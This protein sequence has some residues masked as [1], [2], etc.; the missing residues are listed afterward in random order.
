MARSLQVRRQTVTQLLSMLSLLCDFKSCEKR[1]RTAG[2]SPEKVPVLKRVFIMF[3]SALFFP[4]NHQS[5][6]DQLR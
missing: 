2:D 5:V 4:P 6:T 1:E 3:N